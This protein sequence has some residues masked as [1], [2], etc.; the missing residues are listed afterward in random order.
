[1]CPFHGFSGDGGHLESLMHK[2]QLLFFVT[3][4]STPPHPP[5]L[6]P[7][8]EA[9]Y[10]SFPL[11]PVSE[12]AQKSVARA[13]ASRRVC[14]RPDRTVF[15]CSEAEPE[16]PIGEKFKSDRRESAIFVS[17]TVR[18]RTFATR[19]GKSSVPGSNYKAV[20]RANFLL[21]CVLHS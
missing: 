10:S 4:W 21:N 8:Q 13:P 18:L 12:A 11:C 6:D 9:K 17:P 14:F 15:L 7:S 19:S 5:R 3:P 2:K 1:M 20:S 16:D